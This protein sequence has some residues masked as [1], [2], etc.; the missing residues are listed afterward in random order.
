MRGVDVEL[1][2]LGK[3]LAAIALDEMIKDIGTRTDVRLLLIDLDHEGAH[4][5]IGDGGNGDGLWR[6]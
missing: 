3:L 5:L 2:L 1:S 6:A 4:L